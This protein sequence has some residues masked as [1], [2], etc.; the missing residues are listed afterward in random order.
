MAASA[1][2]R[3]LS[4]EIAE[5]GSKALRRIVRLGP[6]TANG[7]LRVIAHANNDPAVVTAVER[8]LLAARRAERHADTGTKQMFAKADEIL[9]KQLSGLGGRDIELLRRELDH[10]RLVVLADPEELRAAFGP[11]ASRAARVSREVDL[12]AALLQRNFLDRLRSVAALGAGQWTGTHR[13]LMRGC[14]KLLK[15]L[16]GQWADGWEPTFRYL[17]EN[18]VRIAPAVR[19]VRAAEAALVGA[20]KTGPAIA[21]RAAEEE[22]RSARKVVGGYASKVKGSLGEAY[23]PNWADW[24]IQMDSY[25]ELAAREARSLPGTWEARRIVGELRI[26]GAEAWDEAILLINRD[27]RPP[28]AKLFLA[29]QY[30]VEKHDSALE[31]VR[32]DVLRET[33]TA[34]GNLPRVSYREDGVPQIP[35]AL[36]P[37][38][39]G[40]RSHRYVFNAEGGK[41]SA[42]E[43]DRLRAAGIEVNQL[44][45]DVTLD[46]LDRVAQTLLDV[47]ADT[48][49]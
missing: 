46:E 41:V 45:M 35:L 18:A 47:V 14:R 16:G 38:P 15:V 28:Q 6:T 43:I 7:Y 29:A 24:T 17:R 37:M 23:V 2:S 42:T 31:Q 10:R 4:R 49:P 25:L 32:N 9:Q 12:G 22:L 3:Q 30:K 1:Q 8:Y 33:A 34:S 21:V 48:V 13:Q 40:K 39:V 27:T 36:T 5:L 26:D 11:V 44:N 20:R 19:R